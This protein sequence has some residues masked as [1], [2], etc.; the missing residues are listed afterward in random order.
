MRRCRWFDADT[1]RFG[2]SNDRGFPPVRAEDPVC[3]RSLGDNP[4][5]VALGKGVRT[6]IPASDPPS[7]RT[8]D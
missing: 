7:S 4:M 2:E 5:A 6:H 1:P 8:R 3:L